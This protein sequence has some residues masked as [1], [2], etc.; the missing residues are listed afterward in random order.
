MSPV[1]QKKIYIVENKQK[2]F[3][4]QLAM[5]CVDIANSYKYLAVARGVIPG[6]VGVQVPSN[7][8]SNT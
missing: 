5:Y 3:F 2:I 8:W 6:E 4:F 1:Y 7:F